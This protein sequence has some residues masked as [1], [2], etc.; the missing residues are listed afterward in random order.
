MLLS[1]YGKG[2]LSEQLVALVEGSAVHIA[3]DHPARRAVAESKL[4]S[5]GRSEP[6]PYLWIE[7]DASGVSIHIQPCA[8]GR[9]DET[10]VWPPSLEWYYEG[11]HRIEY[12]CSGDRGF[13]AATCSA[14]LIEQTTGLASLRWGYMLAPSLISGHMDE[15][16]FD[17]EKEAMAQAVTAL[18]LRAADQPAFSGI[19]HHENCRCHIAIDPDI[20]T[21][22]LAKAKKALF[23]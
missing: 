19:P 14:A 9:P 2:A 20:D 13:I 7:R 12:R 11:R 22:V 5:M 21:A 3:A 10:I 4:L 6:D 8:G 17:T 1:S 16:F 23:G 18:E 15:K